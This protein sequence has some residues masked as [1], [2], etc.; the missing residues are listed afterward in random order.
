MI[1]LILSELSGPSQFR[2]NRALAEH[3]TLWSITAVLED[4]C[5]SPEPRKYQGGKFILSGKQKLEIVASFCEKIITTLQVSRRGH[6]NQMQDAGCMK[7]L[8]P[9]HHARALR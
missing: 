3:E 9:R 6:W 8:Q 4:D 2:E 1:F 7:N 5:E